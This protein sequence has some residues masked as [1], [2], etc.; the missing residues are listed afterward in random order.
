[1][2]NRKAM[3]PAEATSE[4]A[5][6][7]IAPTSPSPT[8]VESVRLQQVPRPGRRLHVRPQPR[9]RRRLHRS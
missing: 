4:G 3:E 1:M 8:A 5:G 9:I 6:A 2:K 7:V